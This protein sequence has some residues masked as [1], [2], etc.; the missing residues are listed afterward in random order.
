[1][2]KKISANL[3]ILLANS[4]FAIG[5]VVSAICL[6]GMNPVLFALIREG[7][8]GP[9]LCVI[10]RCKE[11]SAAPQKA[12]ICSFML[13][14]FCL[15]LNNLC[16][17]VGIKLAG[18]TAAGIW[19][20]AQ[21]LFITVIAILWGFETAAVLK[22][23]GIFIAIGG[24]LFVLLVNVEVDSGNS[25][26]LGN[27]VLFSQAVFCSLMYVSQKPLLVHYTP[28][29]VLGY[30]YLIATLMMTITASIVN[31]SDYCL[32]KLCPDCRDGGW[33]VPGQAWPGIAY[34]VLIVSA[35]AYFLVAWGNQYVDASVLGIYTVV[36]PVVT[37]IVS[38]IVITLSSAPHW[39]LKG[40]G[41]SDLGAIGIVVGLLIVI[42]DNWRQTQLQAQELLLPTDTHNDI[43]GDEEDSPI[44]DD[45]MHTTEDTIDRNGSMS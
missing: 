24:C 31:Q 2:Q 5:N 13:T 1:M 37:V 19:Q 36:Q 11:G 15:F 10:A 32:K 44:S 7:I 8:S 45:K 25:M 43:M 40:L 30:A 42:Y 38:S 29:T 6:S 21:P 20:P 39:Q 27:I 18:A 3:A 41:I 14:G 16:F 23:V 26:V 28:L 22:F 33:H 9:L 34:F 17:I 4:I 35:A 12:H